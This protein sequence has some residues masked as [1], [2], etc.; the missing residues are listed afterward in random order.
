MKCSFGVASCARIS[1]ARTPPATK[2]TRLVAD[3][4]D[5]DPLVVDVVS[6]LATRPR[7]QADADTDVSALAA[8]R[9]LPR[10]SA[11]AGTRSSRSICAS[12]QSCR[13]AASSSAPLP[14]QRRRAPPGRRASGL[15]AIGGPMSPWPAR[16]WHFAQTPSNVSL[17]SACGS[18]AALREP[19]RRTRPGGSDLD[20]RRA[21]ARAGAPQSSAQRPG[22]RRASSRLEPR[23]VRPARDRVDLAAERGHPPAVDRRR[24]SD[25]RRASTT[26]PTG[27]RSVS[28]AIAP[29]G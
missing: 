5:P 22:T 11:S 3:V 21:S 2:K 25:D 20:R 24:P 16:P 29:F 15:P 13:P 27:T 17:P 28:T 7:V 26:R 8:T 10:R 6:Q 9:R 1:S 12:L 23:V 4:E 14:E 19:A 18:R